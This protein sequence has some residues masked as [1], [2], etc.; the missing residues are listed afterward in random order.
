M[1]T[2]EGLQMQPVEPDGFFTDSTAI[3]RRVTFAVVANTTYMS[4]TNARRLELTDRGV[5]M[6]Q[7]VLQ[8][9]SG[10]EVAAQI[11]MVFHFGTCG[12][13]HK[14]ERVN[15]R[16][17][18]ATRIYGGKSK[19][20]I[21]SGGWVRS[22][23]THPWPPNSPAPKRTDKW[24][25]ASSASCATTTCPS[26]RRRRVPTTTTI[27]MTRVREAVRRARRTGRKQNT[28]YAANRDDTCTST[29]QHGRSLPSGTDDIWTS[30]ANRRLW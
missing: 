22:I 23:S 9:S 13:T 6:W 11:Q 3:Y 7:R 12:R 20:G 2:R 8:L 19:A 5:I 30:R 16:R 27:T 21:L 28:S 26:R 1:L 24:S 14:T 29:A 18:N 17:V 10:Q 4:S 25:K 15:K